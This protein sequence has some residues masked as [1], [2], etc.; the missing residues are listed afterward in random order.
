[1]DKPAKFAHGHNQPGKETRFRKGQVPHN[2]GKP[3]P[4]V[5]LYAERCRREGIPNPVLGR[6]HSEE[7]RRK[8][9][10]AQ[11]AYAARLAKEG[12][13]FPA[14]GRKMPERSAEWRAKISDALSEEKHPNWQGGIGM[15]PYG[16]G[17]TKKFKRLIRDRDN[18]TCQRCGKTRAEL[19][20]TLEV[21]HLDHDKTHNDPT[22]LVTSCHSCNVWASYHRDEPFLRI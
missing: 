11:A 14:L 15:F 17:F 12:K 16:P 8:M 2:K 10:A 1:M 13:P 7:A 20:R 21:H 6:K 9:A 5:R 3:A 18:H 22:N 4:W 19:G